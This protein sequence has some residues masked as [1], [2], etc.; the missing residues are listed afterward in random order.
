MGA[1]GT[2]RDKKT[3]SL[4][5]LG[6]KRGTK[7]YLIIEKKRVINTMKCKYHYGEYMYILLVFKFVIRDCRLFTVNRSFIT[8]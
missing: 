1:Q 4:E 2:K 7:L 5:C 8:L 6:H 3:A